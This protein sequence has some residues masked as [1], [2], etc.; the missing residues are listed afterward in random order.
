MDVQLTNPVNK[1]EIDVSP[2]YGYNGL[3]DFMNNRIADS[4]N[5]GFILA[6]LVIIILYYLL[7]ASIGQ[8]QW[9]Q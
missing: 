1:N 2:V 4:S 5:T 8:P 3:Y 7:F 6:M 9:Q